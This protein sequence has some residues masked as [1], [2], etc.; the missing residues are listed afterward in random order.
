MS[1]LST[2]NLKNPS[3]GSN[4]IVLDSSG[5]VLVGTS[6]SVGSNPLVVVKGDGVNTNSSI[7]FPRYQNASAITAPGPTLGFL[8]FGSAD[9]GLGARIA[10][11]ADASW[12]STSNCPSRLEFSV[13]KQGSAS[14]TESFR[15]S[16]DGSFS[17]V[18]PGGSTLYP[19]FDC[20]AWVNFNGTGTVAIRASGNVSSIT[21]N[22]TGD[23]TVNFTTAMPDVNYAALVSQS[24]DSGGN[25][26]TPISTQN[27]SGTSTK[28]VSAVRVGTGGNAAAYDATEISVA[29]FR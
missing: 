16:N 2:T 26:P 24:R 7:Y 6:S 21:D 5:R 20:R 27:I 23:Y 17:S 9:G 3:S 29:I 28:T 8:E 19:S 13:T 14:A 10:A 4:N 12:G 25:P 15:I 22:G 11:V 1:T 18:I